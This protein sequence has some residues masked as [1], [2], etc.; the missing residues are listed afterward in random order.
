M[1]VI[2]RRWRQTPASA[3]HSIRCSNAKEYERKFIL[4]ITGLA[5]ELSP[6]VTQVNDKSN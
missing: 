5:A 6:G 2:D 3:Y 1:L 4:E